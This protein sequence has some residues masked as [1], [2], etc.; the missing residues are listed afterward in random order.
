MVPVWIVVMVVAGWVVTTVVGNRADSTG[1]DQERELEAAQRE[2]AMLKA[3]LV[4]LEDVNRQLSMQVEWHLK[5]LSASAN[6]TE[7]EQS[8]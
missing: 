4:E 6:S 3:R 1:R 5:M 2:N 8:P 7:K